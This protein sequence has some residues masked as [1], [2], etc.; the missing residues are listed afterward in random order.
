[1]RGFM[2]F[3]FGVL[4][5]VGGA[6]G[7]LRYHVVRAEDGVHVVEKSTPQWKEAYVDIRK[8]GLRE[9]QEH[10]TLAMALIESDKGYLIAET[11]KADLKNALHDAVENLR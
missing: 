6:M 10:S 3:V 8:F 1:M 11:A 9:W 5:G 2:S 4:V 7:G